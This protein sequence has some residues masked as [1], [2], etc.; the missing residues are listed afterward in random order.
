MQKM[1][2]LPS[3]WVN[4]P[5]TVEVVREGDPVS[6]SVTSFGRHMKEAP[7][8]G[9]VIKILDGHDVYVPLDALMVPDVV[10]LLDVQI[11]TAQGLY[12]CAVKNCRNE[13]MLLS[14]LCEPCMKFTCG[15]EGGETSSAYYN[16]VAAAKKRKGAA[17]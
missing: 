15:L 14:S 5:K 16:A 1:Q 13:A 7:R 11:A 9:L 2:P 10:A 17:R 8:D 3:T 12:D 4:V 6:I